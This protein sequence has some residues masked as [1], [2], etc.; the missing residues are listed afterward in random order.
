ML[1]RGWKPNK[2]MKGIDAEE[3]MA[4]IPR[5]LHGNP[6]IHTTKMPYSGYIY[7]KF[8]YVYY[9]GVGQIFTTCTMMCYITFS[10]SLPYSTWILSHYVIN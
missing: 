3:L 5:A 4:R 6:P 10:L 8:I 2:T 7:F 9:P 1:E